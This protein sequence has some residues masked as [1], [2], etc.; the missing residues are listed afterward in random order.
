MKW[1]IALPKDHCQSGRPADHARVGWDV[2]GHINMLNGKYIHTFFGRT[3]RGFG[4][5]KMLPCFSVF[6][7][8]NRK[9]EE[10][11]I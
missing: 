8:S 5:N 4:K 10:L 1:H 2:P 11:R 3:S 9:G 6:F 7:G